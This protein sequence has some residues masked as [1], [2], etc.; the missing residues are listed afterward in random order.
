MRVARMERH[1]NNLHTQKKL[2]HLQEILPYPLVGIGCQGQ[3]E[4]SGFHHCGE[5]NTFIA[6]GNTINK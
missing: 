1:K 4:L 3:Q 5:R 6:W 2:C